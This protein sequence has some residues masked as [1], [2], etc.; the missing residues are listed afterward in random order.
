M[1]DLVLTPAGHLRIVET[2]VPQPVAVPESLS[3]P[4]RRAFGKGPSEGLLYLAT[5][6][7]G[8]ELP[9]VFSY[10]RRLGDRYLHSLCRIPETSWDAKEPMPPL[11]EEMVEMAG[12]APPMTGGEYL[13]AATLE[14]VWT[15]LDQ[16][17]RSEIGGS[18]EGLSHW[19]RKRSPLWHQVG[20]V[21]F[22]LAENRRDS[23]YPFAFLATYAPR[24]LDGRRVQYEPLGRALE[25]QA[26]HD[27]KAVVHLLVPVQR[28]SEKCPWVK[29]LVDSGEIFHPLRWTPKEAY[30]LL[31]DV[32]FLE[33]SGLL[34]RVPDWWAKRPAGV[35]VS[36][37]IGNAGG[38]HFSVKSMLDF[39]VDLAVEG[40][41]L[42][43]AESEAILA[44]EEGLHYL[45]GRWVEVDREKLKAALGQWKRVA[46]Q[47][48][49]DGVSFIEG[50]RLLARAPLGPDL[51][52]LFDGEGAAWSEVR[53]G[54]WLGAR[55][56]ELRTP[57]ALQSALP[58]PDLRATL[59]PYQ[60][61]GVR[62]LRFLSQLGLG[63]CL[64]DDMGLGKTIQVISLLLVMKKEQGERVGPALVVMP[65]S[66]LANWGS[67]MERFA[68][69][70]R[71]RFAHPSR[72]DMR[73]LGK[74]ATDPSAF[75]AGA[76][77]VLTTYGMLSRQDWLLGVRWSV[78]VLDEAQN[79]KNPGSR[80]ARLVKQLNAGS[81]IALTGTPVENR[82]TD[83]WSIFDFLNPSLLGSS[84]VFRDFIKRL[85]K[86][87]EDQYAPLRQLVGPYILRRIKTDRS[88]IADLPEKTE[89]QAYCH[90]TKKQAVLYEQA[91]HELAGA[92]EGTEGVERRGVILAFILRFKQICNHPAQW[93][94]T[95]A[96]ALEESGKFLRLQTLCEEISS[97]QE[98]ALIY[99]QFRTM[100][101]PLASLLKSTFG[102]PGLVLH[103][104]VAVTKRQHLVDEFQRE[105][106]PPFFVLSLKA[107]GTGLNLTAASHVI[108]FDRWWN[109]AVENQATD[110]AYRIGQGKN[111][112]VHKFICRGTIE[113]KID[114]MIRDKTAL[115]GQILEAGAPKSILEMGDKELLELVRLDIAA[116]GED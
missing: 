111:V 56:R 3:V 85:D 7:Q 16:F 116:V 66:L 2:D 64:A 50:M 38:R 18:N 58:G 57:Q 34:V 80:Q 51:V 44:G 20:R 42:T 99:T 53:A 101:D 41:P 84:Q 114:A 115:A 43:P 33:A 59:R 29:A 30:R 86:G 61:I 39:R 24:L 21:C 102:R 46:N 89:M 15:E 70:L 4:L 65:A 31:K 13:Q 11:R 45:K 83:L 68:P 72:M 9:P 69:L 48:G 5:L 6:H 28:A 12:S 96:Y 32:P 106:G 90:L 100:T 78:V 81:R 37:G 14:A 105:D 17:V 113:E 112:M 71:L 63:A 1:L 74:A 73:D 47:F 62:W 8:E 107:G 76:D 88:V 23:E 91:V 92:L 98:K 97:R 22:H 79:I 94:S 75:L 60:E 25:E 10:W 26:G 82:L 93:L 103:G 87:G 55:L 67:E 27:K 110:R 104:E 77:V 36:V 49:P 54:A 109:P 95:G 35:R 40:D 52:P 19:L 108:H